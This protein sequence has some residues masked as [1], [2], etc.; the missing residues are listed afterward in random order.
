[1]LHIPPNKRGDSRG[2]HRTVNAIWFS[3]WVM[4]LETWLS[5]TPIKLTNWQHPCALPQATW[6]LLATAHTTSSW[7]IWQLG[8]T[9]ISRNPS[10][11]TLKQPPQVLKGCSYSCVALCDMRVLRY[12]RDL[13]FSLLSLSSLWHPSRIYKSDSKH[14]KFCFLY[15][16]PLP[17]SIISWSLKGSKSLL[18]PGLLELPFHYI[19]LSEGAFPLPSSFLWGL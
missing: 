16:C 5:L 2:V 6:K 10:N 15:F 8:K 9:M 11:F 4:V 1:M 3:S 14:L 7:Q 13:C 18:L 12:P 17:F 19:L